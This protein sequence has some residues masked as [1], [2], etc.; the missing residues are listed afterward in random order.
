MPKYTKVLP[1]HEFEKLT[2][3]EKAKY[4]IDITELLKPCIV[5]PEN[6][7][8]LAPD[9]VPDNQPDANPPRVDDKPKL[10]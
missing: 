7:S 9:V 1:Q 2:L 8:E 4:L 6:P 5:R 3:D 10:P